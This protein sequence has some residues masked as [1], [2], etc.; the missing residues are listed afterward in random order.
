MIRRLD[1][2]ARAQPQR[3]LCTTSNTRQT[4]VPDHTVEHPRT[5]HNSAVFR[6]QLQSLPCLRRRFT[7]RRCRYSSRVSFYQLPEQAIQPDC[8]LL[9]NDQGRVFPAHGR[10][11]I[12]LGSSPCGAVGARHGKGARRPP[13]SARRSEPQTVLR[14]RAR[15]SPPKAA[16]SS[17]PAAGSGTAATEAVTRFCL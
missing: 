9:G 13:C 6:A 1:G 10:L 2:R 12:I 11:R 5:H 14:R 8:F 3:S 15:P 4:S 7:I 16:S 17:K